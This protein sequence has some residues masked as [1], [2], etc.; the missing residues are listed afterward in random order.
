MHNPS[1]EVESSHGLS[2]PLTANAMNSSASPQPLAAGQVAIDGQQVH[3]DSLFPLAYLGEP[4]HGDL[5]DVT[6]WIAE[7]R[8][9]LLQQA[10]TH[11]AVLLRGFSLRSAEDFDA[12]VREFALKSF[13]YRESLSNAVRVNRTERVF[14][15]NE[16]PPEVQILFHH[17]MAQTPVYPG[18]IFFFCEVAADSGGATPVCRSDVLY[19]RLRRQCPDFIRDCETKGLQYSN[20]MPGTDDPTSGM[21][22]SWKSTLGVDSPEAAETRLRSLNYSWIWLENDCL[23][24]TTPSLPAV[25]EIAPG[26][27][28][29]FNQL[30]AAFRGWKDDRNDPSNAVRHG[31]GSKLNADAVMQAA[32]LADELT[33]DVEWQPGDLVL[34]DNTV[35]MHARRPFTGTRRILASLADPRRQAFQPLM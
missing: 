35:A 13:A 26:R 4:D 29:F 18:R 10:T 25:L 11:G 32:D 1:L 15:A 17:E 20:V 24:A 8:E 28:S 22:R 27:R 5:R 9:E 30:I 2:N 3:G 23:R 33:F 19:E 16:A 31:D 7:H 21:G 34:V 6:R 14:S 12:V